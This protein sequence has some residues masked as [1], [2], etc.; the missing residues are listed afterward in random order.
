MAK[1]WAESLRGSQ[2]FYRVF[3]GFEKSL[4]WFYGFFDLH[5]LS[6]TFYRVFHGFGKAK[7]AYGGLVLGLS[8]FFLLPSCLKK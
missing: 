3:Q 1:R 2:T 5:M 7:Y 8:Q 6:S 4:T